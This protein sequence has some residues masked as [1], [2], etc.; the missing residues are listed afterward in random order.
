VTSVEAL[1]E[2]YKILQPVL[3]IDEVDEVKVLIEDVLCLNIG[4]AYPN[5]I[6]KKIIKSEKELY[7]KRSAGAKQTSIIQLSRE[8]SDECRKVRSC[9]DISD[10][11]KKIFQ[12]KTDEIK[13][14]LA[15]D[16][17]GVDISKLKVP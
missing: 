4:D 13:I 8:I 2:I 3:G 6:L 9:P 11:A 14:R 1:N 16:I 5:D 7:A 17:L 10:E 15:R 12:E